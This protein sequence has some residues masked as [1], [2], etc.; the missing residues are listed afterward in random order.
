MVTSKSGISPREVTKW[1]TVAGSSV[2]GPAAGRIEG[3]RR[4]LAVLIAIN[5]YIN[6]VPKLRSPVADAEG[7]AAIL[8]QHQG[9]RQREGDT[10]DPPVY[11][12]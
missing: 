1:A 7:L 4:N 5:H 2:A 10:R 9:Y 11:A 3:F 12:G 8:R 6:G